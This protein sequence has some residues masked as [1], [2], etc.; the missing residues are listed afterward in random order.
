MVDISYC[1]V[2]LLIVP[3]VSALAGCGKAR[4]VAKGY[5][6]EEGIN[7]EETFAPVAR[8]EAIKI[9]LVFAAHRGSKSTKWM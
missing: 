2:L 3:R 5:C 6:Q 4:L 1:Y 9:F 8:L 7:Y